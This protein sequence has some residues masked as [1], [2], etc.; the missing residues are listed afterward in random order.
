LFIIVIIRKRRR[1]KGAKQNLR[2]VIAAIPRKSP[3]VLSITKFILSN[4]TNKPILPVRIKANIIL[5]PY[6]Y[7]PR[8]SRNR[9]IIHAH[10]ILAI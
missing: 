2:L 5:Q 4:T 1:R 10:R 3:L 6:R 9:F 8:Y 7:K